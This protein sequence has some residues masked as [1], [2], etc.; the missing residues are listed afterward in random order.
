[1]ARVQGPDIRELFFKIR[2]I[3]MLYIRERD[4][5]VYYEIIVTAS[6]GRRWTQERRYQDFQE[7]EMRTWKRRGPMPPF[8]MPWTPGQ[9]S[10]RVNPFGRVGRLEAKRIMLETWLRCLIDKGRMAAFSNLRSYCVAFLDVEKH[11]FEPSTPLELVNNDVTALVVANAQVD[12]QTILLKL[13]MEVEN[14]KGEKGKNSWKKAKA[15][16]LPKPRDFVQSNDV[17][18]KRSNKEEIEASY[19]E[20]NVTNPPKYLTFDLRQERPTVW[21]RLHNPYNHALAFKV[22]ATRAT[23]YFVQP[24]QTVIEGGGKGFRDIAIFIP[25]TKITGD[26]FEDGRDK[27]MFMSH[28]FDTEAANEGNS[29]DG[30]SRELAVVSS[31][32]LAEFWRKASAQSTTRFKLAARFSGRKEWLT[33]LMAH[34]DGAA[35][36]EATT[37]LED[38]IVGCR[39]IG[40]NGTLTSDYSEKDSSIVDESPLMSSSEPRMQN[41]ASTSTSPL[42]LR[43]TKLVNSA[44]GGQEESETITPLNSSE[45]D[46]TAS[47]VEEMQ[48][49]APPG[50]VWPENSVGESRS[51]NDRQLEERSFTGS[52]GNSKRS[53]F[54]TSYMRG[55]LENQKLRPR[56]RPPRKVPTAQVSNKLEVNWVEFRRELGSL[57]PN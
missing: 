49:S 1:M 16:P 25:D 55:G 37:S 18:E 17:E 54:H 39:D 40:G 10:R 26:I 12:V 57:S 33:T 44:E 24:A 36:A 48:A 56:A 3:S 52:S 7:L 46:R 42:L 50:W 31:K 45:F 30:N 23:R 51:A 28:P 4:G 29:S 47:T 53:D 21:L 27:F 32:N 20:I 9:I 2:E 11:C 13:S 41:I 19:L 6:G 35:D 14:M 8:P 34:N 43:G 38:S 5:V 22:M 15:G